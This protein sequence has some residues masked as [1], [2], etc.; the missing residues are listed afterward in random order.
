MFS[1]RNSTSKLGSRISS[2]HPDDQLGLADGEAPHLLTNTA[3]NAR[4]RPGMTFRHRPETPI[5]R[6]VAVP[7]DFSGIFR[8][9]ALAQDGRTVACVSCLVLDVPIEAVASLPAVTEIARRAHRSRCGGIRA[10]AVLR[11][12]PVDAALERLTAAG[13]RAGIVIADTSLQT[14]PPLRLCSNA[15]AAHDSPSS[16][17]RTSSRGAGLCG[18]LRSSRRC[19]RL[20]PDIEIAVE[21][22]AFERADV[23]LDRLEPY[24]DTL[25]SRVCAAATSDG[26]GA[27]RGVA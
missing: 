13:A 2:K 22:D 1:T 20:G 5:I 3:L 23:P 4:R 17:T 6:P 27:D 10:V 26:R 15:L 8:V 25:L 11:I 12:H 16:A 14:A 19:A 21:P 9:S 7:G 18:A 24:V